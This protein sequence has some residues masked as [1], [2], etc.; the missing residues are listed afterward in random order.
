LAWF[1]LEELALRAGAE[2]GAGVLSAPAGVRDL[3]A[4]LGIS[5]DT[6]ARGVARLIDKGVVRREIERDRAG[7]FGP[8]RYVLEL[9]TGLRRGERE[10]IDEPPSPERSR[11]SPPRRRATGKPPARPVSQLSLIDG[12]G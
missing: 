11:P 4:A 3:A 1:V 7:R 10:P 5:K 9:P 6:A 8:S 2:G 12:H